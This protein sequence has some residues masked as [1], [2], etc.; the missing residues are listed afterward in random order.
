M[1]LL[2]QPAKVVLLPLTFNQVF[3]FLRKLTSPSIIH[4]TSLRAGIRLP[5][6]AATYPPERQVTLLFRQLRKLQA[7]QPATSR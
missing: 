3:H 6:Q 1:M 2:Q 4:L 5:A 7:A